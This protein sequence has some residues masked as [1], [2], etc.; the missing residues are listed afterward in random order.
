VGLSP[1]RRSRVPCV[2]DVQVGLGALFV[3]LR[4]LQATLFPGACPT[5]RSALLIGM[6]KLGC[7]PAVSEPTRFTEWALGFKQCSLHHADRA[8]TGPRPSGFRRVLPL[9]NMLLSSLPFGCEVVTPHEV[10]SLAQGYHAQPLPCYT[11]IKLRRDAAHQ[12]S[13]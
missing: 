2:V 4:S 7:F 13:R 10:G 9:P 1:G 12:N 8:S 6:G 3:P 11:G 5:N